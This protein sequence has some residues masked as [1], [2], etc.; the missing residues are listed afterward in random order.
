MTKVTVSDINNITVSV[1]EDIKKVYVNIRPLGSV[2]YTDLTDVDPIYAGHAGEVVTVN[3]TETGLEFA[4][5]GGGGGTPGGADKSIQF[6]DA[7]AFGGFGS[8][9]KVTKELNKTDVIPDADLSSI[10]LNPDISA[11]THPKEFKAI[12]VDI[13]QS[14]RTSTQPSSWIKLTDD[15]DSAN[16]EF[17][18]DVNTGR[19][20]LII[21]GPGGGYVALECGYH[22]GM[23]QSD[24]A[25]IIASGRM[26]I[27]AT[28]LLLNEVNGNGE[29][30]HAGAQH[31]WKG[32]ADLYLIAQ[33]YFDSSGYAMFLLDRG[34]TAGTAKGRIRFNTGTD[35]LEFSNDDGATYINPLGTELTQ[36]AY[37]ALAPPVTGQVY[38]IYG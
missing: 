3:A 28:T 1:D 33:M 16:I 14:G 34:P 38:Y 10:S 36:S 27:Q 20:F 7:N 12:R 19:I 4:A 2:A 11:Q 37:T 15:F 21:I 9:D 8:Y 17:Y 31:T 24:D 25:S 26:D 30:R 6:N 22:V 32:D 13:K 23:I 35:K 18:R 5:G 29:N